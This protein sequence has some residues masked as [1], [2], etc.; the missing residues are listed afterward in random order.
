MRTAYDSKLLYYLCIAAGLVTGTWRNTL[1]S[2]S[3][4]LLQLVG[5]TYNLL[6]LFFI[7]RNVASSI[8]H[9]GI[10]LPL[11]HISGIVTLSLPLTK[12]YKQKIF[13]LQQ[14]S[15]IDTL[16]YKNTKK[17][18]PNIILA[19]IVVIIILFHCVDIY[20]WNYNNGFIMTT[21]H[22]IIVHISS[23]TSSI[24]ACQYLIY[25]Q[26]IKH[27][28][29]YLNK[30]L[31]NKDIHKFRQIYDKLYEFC[32]LINSIY[33]LQI[34]LKILSCISAVI[35]NAYGTLSFLH[36]LIV[37][38]NNKIIISTGLT[39]IGWTLLGSFKMIIICL[40]CQKAS[41]ESITLIS[42]VQKLLLQENITQNI[43]I[44]LQLFS[45]QIVR[46][47]TE[48]TANGICVINFSLMYT[49]IGILTTY[50]IVL[51]QI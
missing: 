29:H 17:H 39:Q 14:A 37:K 4:L 9:I 38:R 44:Q 49:I 5:L 11:N 47:R 22:E 42:K 21:V 12:K 23:I 16:M 30:S 41:N 48:F 36:S 15:N 24:M 25:V 50:I 32:K 10:T 45:K 2:I 31:N 28:L 18:M 20:I 40:L 26:A 35:T 7:P 19:P 51:I 33:G 34:F 13:Y 3:L 27:H 46:N 6:S 1:W 43:M 8:L